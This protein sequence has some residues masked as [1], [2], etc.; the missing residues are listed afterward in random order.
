MLLYFKVLQQMSFDLISFCWSVEPGE[1]KEL[2][3]LS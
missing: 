1:G 2:A 3:I